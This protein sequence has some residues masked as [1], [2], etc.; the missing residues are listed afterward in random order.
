MYAHRFTD[1]LRLG[2]RAHVVL[3]GDDGA[4]PSSY[5][6][7]TTAKVAGWTTRRLVVALM[8]AERYQG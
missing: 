7:N 1:Y 3:W 6:S 4:M 8:H 5:D 2:F